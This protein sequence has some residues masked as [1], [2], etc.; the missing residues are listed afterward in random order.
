MRRLLCFG[1]FLALSATQVA[2]THS[3]VTVPRRPLSPSHIQHAHWAAQTRSRSVV[4]R[5]R[6]G[7]SL[8]L[9]ADGALNPERISDD[10]AYQH[11]IRAIAT[12]ANPSPSETARRNAFIERIG[13]SNVD[14]NALIRALSPVRA[15]LDDVAKRRQR[16]AVNSRVRRPAVVVF[17]AEEDAI[18]GRAR[19]RIRGQL[20]PGGR[21]L[22]DAH[23]QGHVK[24]RIKIYDGSSQ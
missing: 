22:L 19:G 12:S 23:I 16:T 5:T 9:A 3:A 21:R 11:F 18:T 7:V 20:S 24:R 10:L 13:L 8:S 14:R 6:S 1:A 2:S 15:E 17:K 4:N